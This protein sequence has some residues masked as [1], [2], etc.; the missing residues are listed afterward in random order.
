[1]LCGRPVIATDVVGHREI[2]QDGV[3]GFLAEAPT[4]TSFLAALERFWERRHEA[5][6][7]GRTAAQH[8]SRL[9]PADPVREFSDKL[10]HLSEVA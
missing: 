2:V 5:E 10:K 6:A 8:I 7:I 3:T 4:A 9:L 1:M